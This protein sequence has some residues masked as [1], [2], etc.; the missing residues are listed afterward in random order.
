M[1]N[2]PVMEAVRAA[3]A[4]RRNHW[5][6][7]SSALA[8]VTLGSTLDLVGQ[9]SSQINLR[10]LGVPL[11]LIGIVISYAGLLRLAFQDEHQGDPDMKMG[12]GGL[13]WAL[14]ELRLLSVVGL[15]LVVVAIFTCLV[16]L[17]GVI[18]AV[19]LLTSGA[20]QPI[21][22][23]ATPEE[24]AAALTPQAG[25]AFSAFFFACTVGLAYVFA[26]LSL[27]MP[28]T[29]S[30]GAVAV[31]QTWV[32]TKGQAWR[33]FGAIV[34]SNAPSIAASLLLAA[35]LSLMIGPAGVGKLSIVSALPLALIGGAV[36]GFV[37]IP[38]N[39]GLVAFLYRGL[40]PA[41][42]R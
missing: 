28:A 8:I 23:L 26:R 36:T 2:V 41:G 17:L 33:I 10:Y 38:I 19:T 14:P 22:K 7:V 15:M 24:V 32:L 20:I 35:L 18:L 9:L 1:S 27:A 6:A 39:V 21:S 29:I 40:R 37:Q 5:R 34:L 11:S 42:E 3:F 12:A 25:A 30:R 16:L 4:F 31:F 13:Q